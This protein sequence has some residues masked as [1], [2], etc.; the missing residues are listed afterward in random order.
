[1]VRRIVLLLAAVS[2]CAS[3]LELDVVVVDPCNKPVLDTLKLL[4]YEARGTDLGDRSSAFTNQADKAFAEVPIPLVPDFQLVVMGY[5]SEEVTKLPDAAGVSA[6]YDLAA[7]EGPLTITVPIAPFD[8]F[9]KPTQLDDPGTCTALTRARHGATATWVPN[10]GKVVI[11][12]G[13]SIVDGAKLYPRSVEAF[14]PRTGTFDTIYEFK[15]QE[16]GQRAYHTA[17]LISGD[18]ILLAGG[19]SGD[20]A[21][22]FSTR[23]VVILNVSDPTAVK[24]DPVPMTAFL[25]DE[26]SGHTAVKLANGE[27]AFIGGRKL[28]TQ[29]SN[30]MDQT[31]QNTI[32][33]F[34]PD[35]NFMYRPTGARA[36]ADARY[37][38]SATL[39]GTGK[40]ILVVG[41]YS[42]QG[43]VRSLEIVHL[44][45]K[46]AT[47]SVSTS[48]ASSSVGP[49]Y[50]AAAV[51]EAGRVFL[52]G[53]FNSV[54]DA[55]PSG[56]PINIPKNP[57]ATVEIWEFNDATKKLTKR[58]T[59]AM[60]TA[61]GRHTM[62]LSGETAIFV[63]G[64]GMD[65]TTLDNGEFAPYRPEACL[66]GRPTVQPMADQRARHAAVTLGTGEILVVGGYRWA[67]SEM[68]YT[69]MTGA[70]LFSP[71]RKP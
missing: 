21:T 6:Q 34:E 61:R 15:S 31:F 24:V 67:A 2:G 43:P 50:H 57:T 36:L 69:S 22:A 30:P 37:G 38:H 66:V 32:E 10:L 3:P 68:V 29:S 18:R 63:G 59:G 20:G 35:T 9:Y 46:N 40:D 70:E 17:T 55:D 48:S 16:G 53:G 49:I 7:A 41:G 58:C 65:G 42:D 8:D 26:R 39:L 52:S 4:G 11:V 51:D 47:N 28:V 1:M 19:E 64:H 5:A 25:T 23:T 71:R 13:E 44:E 14:D 27:V 62:A 33:V 56:L 60:A 45:G 54:A 12:G